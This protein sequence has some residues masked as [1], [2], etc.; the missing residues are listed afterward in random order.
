MEGKGKISNWIT[1]FKEGLFEQEWFKQL[2][3]KWSELDVETQTNLQRLGMGLAGL[4]VVFVIFKVTWSSFQ[5]KNQVQ[6]KWDLLNYLQGSNEEMRKLRDLGSGVLQ[7]GEK[8]SVEPWP[9]YFETVAGSAGIPKSSFS[10]L[11]NQ[12]GQSNDNAK[13][14]L[15]ELLLKRITLQQAVQFAYNIENGSRTVKLLNLNL[16]SKELKE[17]KDSGGTA[18]TPSTTATVLLDASFLVSALTL[19]NK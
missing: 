14:Q 11:E 12:P 3:E 19:L 2:Q 13:E 1:N 16:E 18:A 17:T 5:L 6:E 7:T 10:V 4:L 9:E 8:S 15:M